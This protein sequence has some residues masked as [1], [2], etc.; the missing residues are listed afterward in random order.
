MRAASAL[1]ALAFA[2]VGY[3]APVTAPTNHTTTAGSG[4][5][6]TY[7]HCNRP[8]VYAL[9][10]DDGPFEYSWNLAK[11]LNSRGVKATFF[12]NGHNFF[13]TNFNTTTTPTTADGLKTYT[14]VLQLYDSLGHEVASHTYE[15][16]VLSSS[17]TSD[18][19]EAQLNQQSDLIFNAIGKRPALFRPPEGALS[20][21]AASIVHRLGYSNIL[22]DVDTKDYEKRGLAYEQSLIRAVVDKDVHGQTPGHISLQHD[23]HAESATELTPWYIDYLVGKNY[24]FVTVSD[25]L[26]IRGYQ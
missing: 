4:S 9:T 20:D 14:E 26:G 23:V 1:L 6:V 25:C 24:T 21:S 11:Y 22:W 5:L 10:F 19:V 15:H 17:L 2:A 16:L 13:K 18:Q 8:G 7:T 3:A 12:T